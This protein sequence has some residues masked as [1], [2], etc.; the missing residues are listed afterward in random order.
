MSGRTTKGASPAPP[1][2]VPP[3]GLPPPVPGTG[4]S[5][6]R[7][8]WRIS[9]AD[10]S[11][12]NAV[13]LYSD[14]DRTFDAMLDLI[15]SAERSVEMEAYIL[16]DDAVGERFAQALGYAGYPELQRTVRQAHR[17]GLG[18]RVVTTA[19]QWRRLDVREAH[20]DAEAL[21]LGE[22]LRRRKPVDRQVPEA[23]AQVLPDGHHV[24][25]VRPHVAHRLHDLLERLA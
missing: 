5:Y 18:V 21:V 20:L 7:A 23:W 3:P 2:P 13:L 8:L 24:D 6:A 14:G 19:N 17:P 11:P 22:L 16:R 9:S 15:A 4:C 12:G 10:V 1:A 25:T